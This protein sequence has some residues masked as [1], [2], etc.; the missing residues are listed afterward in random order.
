MEN[1]IFDE[2]KMAQTSEL[3]NLISWPCAN[4]W[5]TARK[6]VALE[7]LRRR[8]ITIRPPRRYDQKRP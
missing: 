2:L 7:V 6:T 8:G 3:R 1:K 4:E 5:D